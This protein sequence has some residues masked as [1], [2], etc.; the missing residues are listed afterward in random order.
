MGLT[1][2]NFGQ[3]FGWRRFAACHYGCV[4]GCDC[5]SGYW[6]SVSAFGC[7]VER[8][9]FGDFFARGAEAG[10]ERG[11]WRS[12]FGCQSD[13]GCAEGWSARGGDSK[14][15]CRVAGSGS[16]L[17]GAEG[18]DPGGPESG[19]CGFGACGGAAGESSAG[20]EE[21]VGNANIDF[22]GFFFYF[23]V[24][25]LVIRPIRPGTKISPYCWRSGAVFGGAITPATTI[26]YR[27][28]PTAL[29]S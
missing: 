15:R 19:E 27:L 3:A 23:L 22:H 14:A 17:C 8:R 18:E 2:M 21:E 29:S 10:A 28:E 16:R 11:L 6:G 4:A 7:E 13:S 25:S 9:G 20:A 12:E 24:P 26:T 5:G 1:R